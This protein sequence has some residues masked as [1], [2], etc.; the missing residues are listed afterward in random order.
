[1]SDTPNAAVSGASAARPAGEK[2]ILGHPRGLAILFLTEMWERFSYYGM[3]ALLIFYLTQH[4]LFSDERSS[5]I[6]GAYVSLVYVMTIVGGALA[7]RYLGQRKAVAFG[8]ILLVFGH[9]GMAFEG[10]GSKEYLL[11]DGREQEIRYEGR[12]DNRQL[13]VD[14]DGAARRVVFDAQRFATLEGPDGSERRLTPLADDGSGDYL[15]VKTTRSLGQNLCNLVGLSCRGEDPKTT[16]RLADGVEGVITRTSG[17]D[18]AYEVV[19]IDGVKRRFSETTE[20]DLLVLES[21]DKA[22]APKAGVLK[23]YSDGAYATRVEQ[24]EFYLN[25]LYLSLALIIAG[26]GFLKANISTIV[27]A[28][29]G[30]G[31]KRRDAGFTIFYMGIN[32]GAFLSSILCGWL[33][34]AYG[35]KYGFGLAGIGM[36]AG[37]LIFLRYQPWL[38]GRAEPPNPQ[39]LKQKVLGPLNVEQTCYLTGVMMVALSMG[40]VMN[41]E[42]VGGLLTPI[43]LAILAFLIGYAFV[44][45]EGVE[46]DRMLVAIYVT[47]AQIPFWALFE[48]AGSSLNLFTDRLV[49]RT[50]FGFDVPAPI[51]QSLNAG[52]IF[53]FAPLVAW[54]W[55]ALYKRGLEPTTP[56]KFSLGVF[57][58][59]L[60]FL[61]LVAG[62]RASGPSGLTPVYFIFLIYWIHTMGELML[63][64][65]GLSAVTKLAPAR[66]VGMTM[67]AWFLFSG[68]SN[69]LAGVIARTTG[70]ET[71]GGQIV[72]AASAKAGY[73]Q[74]YSNVGYVA[75]AIALLMLAISPLLKKMMHGAD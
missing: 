58:A 13:F 32:L 71:I 18:G 62:M 28:L 17:P 14:V 46:R 41:E 31:D 8:A 72:D 63:S 56:V 68:F 54:A 59:G 42:L 20:T 60:G 5:L 40:L 74:V 36:L 38:D 35:W 51:F 2:T 44:K 4:F 43:G 39:K 61:A 24:D 9:F 25:I 12:G 15:V 49:D 64:P 47:L 33:G 30:V 65:V 19:E 52:F 7:D 69:Y 22:D 11:A 3:R 10:E 16:L 53:L 75:M 57:M 48:Q 34:F 6:Y 23:R 67:G 1:M 55:I 70:A 37:L 66:V 26:V 29:Y 27:G 50:A 73:M 45:L 21:A